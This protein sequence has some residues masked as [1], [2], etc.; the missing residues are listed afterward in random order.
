MLPLGLASGART[1]RPVARGEVIARSVVELAEGSLVVA[2]RRLQ[3]TA[4]IEG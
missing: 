3:D 1:T 2:L 4:A